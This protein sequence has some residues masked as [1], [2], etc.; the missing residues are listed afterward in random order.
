MS[1]QIT[2]FFCSDFVLVLKKLLH[3]FLFFAITHF[4]ITMVF[5]FV[6]F[7]F[8]LTQTEAFFSLSLMAPEVSLYF[9]P[10][11]CPDIHVITLR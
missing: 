8:C 1:D 3:C 11:F 9:L 10:F 6:I 5:L 4:N 2:I 7:T